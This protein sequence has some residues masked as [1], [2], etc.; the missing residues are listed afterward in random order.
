MNDVCSSTLNL[1]EKEV[2]EKISST[3]FPHTEKYIKGKC[4]G[5]M[6]PVCDAAGQTWASLLSVIVIT[7]NRLQNLSKRIVIKRI[8]YN[9]TEQNNIS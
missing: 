1:T 9:R 5:L 3:K 4:G 8:R 6:F 2:L 7:C